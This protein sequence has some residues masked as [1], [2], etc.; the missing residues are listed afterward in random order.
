VNRTIFVFLFKG[1]SLFKLHKT[2]SSGYTT[3]V[4]AHEISGRPAAKNPGTG[5]PQCGSFLVPVVGA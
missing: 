2:D 3:Q 4:V 1:P 5:A